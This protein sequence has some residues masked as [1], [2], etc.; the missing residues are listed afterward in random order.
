MSAAP[1][2]ETISITEVLALLDGEFRDFAKGVADGRYA[3]WLGSGISLFRFPGLKDLVVKVLEYLRSRVDPRKDDCPFKVG[4]DRALNLANLSDAEKARIEIGVAAKDWPVIG[5]LRDRLSGQY[6]AFLNID[7]D[8]QP[9]DLLVWEG[10][11]VAGTYGDDAIAPDAEHYAIALLIKEGLVSD[12]PS[13]NWDGLIEKSVGEL[14]SVQ[15]EL[16]VCVRSEDLQAPDRRA[17]LIKFHGCAIRARGDDATYREYLVGAQRQIDSWGKPD[18]NTRGIAQYL[19]TVAT[20]KPTLMMGFSAQDANIRTVFGLAKATQ[21]WPWPGELP[22][23]V[24]A[25]ETIGEAQ[26]ALLSNVYNDKFDGG[27]RAAI[28][29]SAHIQVYAK[30]LLTALIL[31]TGASKLQRAARLGDFDLTNELAD[32]VDEGILTL[33]DHAAAAND[34]DHLGFVRGL[35]EGVTRTKR[36]SLSGKSD[37]GLSRYEPLTQVPI[38]RMVQDLETETNGLAETAIIAATLAKGVEAGAWSLGPPETSDNGAGTA[39]LS[40]G[41]RTERIFVL[42]KPEAE[43]AL[44]ASEAVLEEDDDVVLIH[45]RPTQERL[46]RSSSRAPG[47]TGDVGP[48]KVIMANLIS[49]TATPA[50]LMNRFRLELGL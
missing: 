13:A 47:R 26:R 7:I 28:V 6:A 25:E 42:A 20:T 49:E 48:R 10:V 32:W 11:D 2:A 21:T 3:F 9:L 14:G 35:I 27:D 12:L 1:K 36:I 30:P 4:L 23:Y 5:L 45:A 37:P 8:G 31:W 24:M 50:E 17:T 38:G 29:K 22:A 41:A 33:R 40:A 18:S 19:V 46:Q 16:K 15:D 43:I 44:Y 39:T 34:G